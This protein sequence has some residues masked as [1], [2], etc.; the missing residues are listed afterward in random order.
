MGFM[1]LIVDLAKDLSMD[2]NFQWQGPFVS[3]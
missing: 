1:D 3:E 2:C